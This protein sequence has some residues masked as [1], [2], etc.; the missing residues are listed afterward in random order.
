MQYTHPPLTR[1][2]LSDLYAL[3]QPVTLSPG[4]AF[5]N[6]GHTF[7]C[8]P[9]TIFEPV[10]EYQ[11]EL[12][13]ELARRESQTVRA[14][15]VGHSPSDLACTSGFMVRMSRLNQII[16]VRNGLILFACIWGR[17]SSARKAGSRPGT[18]PHRCHSIRQPLP[19]RLRTAH[20]LTLS[21]FRCFVF[22]GQRREAVRRCTG[23]RHSPGSARRPRSSWPGHD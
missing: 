18:S 3:L 9:L 8:T 13:L 12:I 16:E 2:S 21:F 6:W 10:S 17:S 15:G 4:S 14:V 19:T 22:L 20:L 7:R 11:C 5:R 1:L 23:W